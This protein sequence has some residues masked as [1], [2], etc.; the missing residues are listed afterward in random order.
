MHKLLPLLHDNLSRLSDLPAC[1]EFICFPLHRTIVTVPQTAPA[2]APSVP[3]TK[4]SLRT[5][6][7]ISTEFWMVRVFPLKLY[8]PLHEEILR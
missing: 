6:R 3:D 4:I 1:F 7:S 2:P 8:S 5:S